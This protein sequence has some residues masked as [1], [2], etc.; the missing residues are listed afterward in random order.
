MQKGM[1]RPIIRKARVG[2]ARFLA[3]ATRSVVKI[4]LAKPEK[5]IDP[6]DRV[7]RYIK[8][9]CPPNLFGK[10]FYSPKN[11]AYRRKR[12]RRIRA[13]LGGKSAPK[14]N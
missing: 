5:A 4:L 10:E 11:K 8:P 1:K 6:E 12:S 2:L 3:S 13:S 14:F 9:T 7:K